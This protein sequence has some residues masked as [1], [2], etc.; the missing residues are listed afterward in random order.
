MQRD[1][2]LHQPDR[3]SGAKSATVDVAAEIEHGSLPLILNMD[4]WRSVIVEIHSDHDPEES[5]DFRHW[6]HPWQVFF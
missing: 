3:G 4:M 2:L 6:R 1:P 5:A